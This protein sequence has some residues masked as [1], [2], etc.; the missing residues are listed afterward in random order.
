VG[1]LAGSGV[2]LFARGKRGLPLQVIAAATATFGIL[3]GKYFAFV[4]LVRDLREEQ[5]GSVGRPAL[6]LF[7]RETFSLFT[8]GSTDLFSGFDVVWF[9]LAVSTAWWIVA[10]RGSGPIAPPLRRT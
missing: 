8:D 6:P 7:S 3:W 2:A 5:F 9:V 4:L 1:V 10:R